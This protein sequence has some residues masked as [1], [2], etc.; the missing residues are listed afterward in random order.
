[1]R[2]HYTMDVFT[3]CFV[4]LCVVFTAEKISAFFDARLNKLAPVTNLEDK[5][6]LENC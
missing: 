5:T 2:A 4:A 3:G 6:P 1:L